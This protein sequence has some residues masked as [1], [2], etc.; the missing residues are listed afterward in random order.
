MKTSTFLILE[1]IRDGVDMKKDGL[2]VC[3]PTSGIASRT[4]VLA[5]AYTLA[6]EYNK[7]LIIIWRKT[8]DCDCLYRDVYAP[9]QFSDITVHVYECNQYTAKFSELLKMKSLSGVLKMIRESG[10]RLTYICK[11]TVLYHYYRAKC[12]IYKNSYEDHNALF[13]SGLARNNGCFFEAYN[14]ITG[15]GKLADIH[16]RRK[17]EQ[18]AEDILANAGDNIIGVHIRRTDHAL[19]KKSKTQHFV[20]RMKEEIQNNPEVHFYLATDDWEEQFQM[21]ERFGD[22]IIVQKDKTLERSSKAGMYSGIIDLLCLSKTSRILG[23]HSSIFSKF[24]AE[25]GRIPLEIM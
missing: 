18:E 25:Y 13:D 3:E 17:F 19:A 21:T 10:I 14:C 2:I 20:E 23:S 15:K 24:A 16:F 6:K 4:Y 1:I 12:Q 5:D 22:R 7:K 8:S 9:E 11:H